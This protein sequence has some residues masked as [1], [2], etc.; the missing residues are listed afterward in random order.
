MRKNCALLFFLVFLT[1]GVFAVDTPVDNGTVLLNFVVPGAAQIAQGKSEGWWYTPG[2]ALTIGGSLL[3][4]KHYMPVGDDYKWYNAAGTVMFEGGQMLFTYSYYAYF[5]DTGKIWPDYQR[6]SLPFLMASPWLPQNFTSVDVFPIVGLGILTSLPFLFDSKRP[7]YI[8]EYFGSKTVP[9]WGADMN[10]YLA[11]GCYFS[12]S[13]VMSNFTA[14]TEECLFRGLVSGTI[15]ALP[16]SALFGSV[17]A[18]NLLVQDITP[19]TIR[20]TALQVAQSFCMGLYLDNLVRENNGD[21]QKAI[22]VHQWWNVAAFSFAFFSAISDPDYVKVHRPTPDGKD[23]TVSSYLD[24]DCHPGILLK[25][26]Y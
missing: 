18:A 20:N 10:P 11:Y 19:T 2:L 8:G 5:N 9:F 17:H 21:L 3:Q 22:T 6:Q 7:E 4:G 16:S 15:P 12:W 23:L 26:R 25:Y 14:V 24:T 1:A 13:L